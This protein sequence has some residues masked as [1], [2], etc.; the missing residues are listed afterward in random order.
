MSYNEIY[1]NFFGNYTL[2]ELLA[3]LLM[4]AL[5]YTIMMSKTTIGYLMRGFFALVVFHSLYT[6]I[7]DGYILYGVKL[8]MLQGIIFFLPLVVKYLFQG[9]TIFVAVIANKYF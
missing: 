8:A 2:N 3:T 1:K 7:Q 9:I 4:I 6:N 5:I